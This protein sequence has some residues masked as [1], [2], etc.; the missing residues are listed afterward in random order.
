MPNKFSLKEAKNKLDEMTS[1]YTLTG[2]IDLIRLLDEEKVLNE[3]E[4]PALMWER[5]LRI[6]TPKFEGD[7]RPCYDYYSFLYG[8]NIHLSPSCSSKPI[9]DPRFNPHV[10]IRYH[11]AELVITGDKSE[12]LYNHVDVYISNLPQN[13]FKKK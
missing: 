7:P 12:K 13:R 8:F 11:N 6:G 3:L 2:R 10:F 5:K 4:N 9:S 1:E